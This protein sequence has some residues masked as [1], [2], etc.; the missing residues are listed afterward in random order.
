MKVIER[1][2]C[3]GCGDVVTTTVQQ[4]KDGYLMGLTGRKLKVPDAWNNMNK[5]NNYRLGVKNGYDIYPERLT[6]RI[7]EEY[8]E[9][10]WDNQHKTALAEA[11]RDLGKVE[12]KIVNNQHLTEQE[13]L[14]KEDVE[15]KVELLV[16]SDKKFN[17]VGPTYDCILFH[18]GTKWLCCVDTSEKGDLEACPLLGEYSITHDYAPLTPND[19]LNFS[20]NVHNNGDILELVGLC[21]MYQFIFKISLL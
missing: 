19:Q 10:Q 16:N 9:K 3:S 12:A 17:D 4:P 14:E 6:D 15:L 20:I 7:K 13:K 11:H 21:C 18:D 2:D 1:F 5:T 8:K